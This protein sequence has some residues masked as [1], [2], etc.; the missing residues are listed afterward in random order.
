M[1]EERGGIS[2]KALKADVIDFRGLTPTQLISNLTLT[3]VGGLDHAFP[4]QRV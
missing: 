3:E 1:N 4:S 2:L